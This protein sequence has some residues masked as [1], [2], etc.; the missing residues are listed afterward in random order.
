[1][2][3]RWVWRAWLLHHPGGQG[4]TRLAHQL[5]HQLAAGGWAVLWPRTTAGPERLRELRHDAK[6]LLVVLDYAVSRTDQIAALVEAS[7]AQLL[8]LY[9]GLLVLVRAGMPRTKPHTVT[10]GAMASIGPEK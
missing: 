6:P 4:K 3:A 9:Q 1:M 8:A 2:L 7:A 10:D 5:A